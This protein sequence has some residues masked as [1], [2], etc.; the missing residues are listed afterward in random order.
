MYEVSVPPRTQHLC[1]LSPAKLCIPTW[2]WWLLP[3]RCWGGAKG[4]SGEGKA[5]GP[6]VPEHPE[7][8]PG[9]PK[10]RGP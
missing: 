4:G 10:A 8:G 9:T 5:D 7:G 3:G 6:G 2:Q 1:W